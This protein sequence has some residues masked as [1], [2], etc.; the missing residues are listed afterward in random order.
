VRSATSELPLADRPGFLIRRLHQ[1]HVA[2][3]LEECG[4]FDVTPV[5]YSVMTALIR[6]GPLDQ[7]S[8]AREIGIDRA[9]ATD[10]LRRL[11]ERRLIRRMPSD[12]DS[13]AKICALTKRGRSLALKMQGAAER[14]HRRTI[15]ALPKTERIAFTR[16]LVRLVQA[17]NELG[18]AKL[19]LR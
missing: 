8:L 11:D 9:N 15:A 12:A 5:Q 16:S 2:M 19:R 4:S 14:A 17:N 18:R 6:H 1:I 7:A 10:V 3:F 13:R